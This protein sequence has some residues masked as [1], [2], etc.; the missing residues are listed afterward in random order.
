M[1]RRERRM[2]GENG[3]G[4]EGVECTVCI[5]FNKKKTQ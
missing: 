4:R 5:P 1:E 3:K 2:K